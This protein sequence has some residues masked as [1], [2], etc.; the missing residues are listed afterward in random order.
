MREAGK[1]E[2]L[3]LD[4]TVHFEYLIVNTRDPA[5]SDPDL[6]AAL[7]YSID[8]ERLCSEILQGGCVPT[9]FTSAPA[10]LAGPNLFDP[11]AAKRHWNRARIRPSTVDLLTTPEFEQQLV[12]GFLQETWK[13]HLGLDVRVRNLEFG[14][15]MG[16]LFSAQP[17]QLARFWV[18]P[19]VDLPEIWF[20]SFRPGDPP[21]RGRNF[22]AY[23]NPDLK[24]LF[25]R[26]LSPLDSTQRREVMEAMEAVLRRDPPILPLFQR[27]YAYLVNPVVRLPLGYAL[28]YHFWDARSESQRTQAPDR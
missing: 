13:N 17:F 11:A 12:A 16:S 23:A 2:L 7:L 24:P 18:Q 19:L 15:L 3:V 21:P 27:K 8:R 26:T 6:R 1:P 25:Q 14:A 22:S 20:M 5:L 9:D 4:R 28:R 10:K